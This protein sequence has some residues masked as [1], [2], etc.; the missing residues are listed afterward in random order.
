ML[1]SSSVVCGA[2]AV[3]A[4]VA[5]CPLTAVLSSTLTVSAIA[6]P[7]RVLMRL[8]RPFPSSN[9]PSAAAW[10]G[11]EWVASALEVTVATSPAGVLIAVSA[12]ESTVAPVLAS[13]VAATASLLSAS[14]L[15]LRVERTRFRPPAAACILAVVDISGYA[16][17]VREQS[18]L[19]A[20]GASRTATVHNTETATA[21]L[22]TSRS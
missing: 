21:R 15:A 11:T 16:V 22:W 19:L 6:P 4:V 20:V 7:R 5:L 2:S 13:V 12:A 18:T 14:V 3:A 1:L 9:A 10:Y 8:P 17:L